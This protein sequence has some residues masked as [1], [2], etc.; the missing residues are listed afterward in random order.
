MLSYPLSFGNADMRQQR[1][2]HLLTGI[3]GRA[4]LPGESQQIN[5]PIPERRKSK[6]QGKED[7][8]SCQPKEV[9]RTA[10]RDMS[11][12]L[13]H[14]SPGIHSPWICIKPVLAGCR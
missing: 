8:T 5:F 13:A 6:E 4:A 3:L 1:G 10:G 2:I 7:I 12:L 11:R 14:P 9:Q